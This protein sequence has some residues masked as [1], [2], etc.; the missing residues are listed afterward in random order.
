MFHCDEFTA[1][2]KFV[3]CNEL[4]KEPAVVLHLTGVAMMD[5]VISSVLVLSSPYPAD[6]V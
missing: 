2:D 6:Y 3:E 1:C 4:T 5:T